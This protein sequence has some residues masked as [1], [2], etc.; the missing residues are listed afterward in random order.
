MTCIADDSGL[1][2]DALEGAPGVLSARYAGEDAS[3]E[4]NRKKLLRMLRG[5]SDDQRTARFVCEIAMIA[6]DG[7]QV[8][9]RGVCNGRIALAEQ[10]QGGFGYDSIFIPDDPGDGRT[11]AELTAEHKNTVS[12]RGLALAELRRK[13]SAG[14]YP[15]IFGESKPKKD[16]VDK[17]SPAATT[18]KGAMHPATTSK[19]SLAVFDF[20]GT[21]LDGASPVRLVRFL[22]AKRIMPISTGAK[23]G[24]WA[25]KYKF[26]RPVE[27][28]EVRG[29]VFDGMQTLSA[30]QV[31]D[32]MVDLYHDEL[33]PL[34]RRTGLAQIEQ[35]KR[36]G[37]RVALVSASFRPIVSE[38]AKDIGTDLFVCTEMEIVDGFYTGNVIC[39]PPEGVH[40]LLQL[41][42]RADELFGEGNWTIDSAWGDH[43]SDEPILSAA[44]RPVAVN[45]ERLL[46]MRATSLNWTI[47]NWQ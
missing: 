15:D 9:A 2:V 25:F 7:S 31:R 37:K 41:K 14:S 34:L 5:V 44:L 39:A 36:E 3:D 8:S 26:N 23:I 10:G 40:K 33:K 45:P 29:Y 30:D 32:L 12:H 35:A 21:L 27:Q 22:M 13:L 18:A 38:L 42:Q 46:R 16:Y 17:I 4:D 1:E 43:I 20:D 28:A 11:M 47:C 19:V 24:R 6:A